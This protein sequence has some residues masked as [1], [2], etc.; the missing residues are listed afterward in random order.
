MHKFFCLLYFI[1]LTKLSFGQ[2]FSPK[3]YYFVSPDSSFVGVKDEF[4]KVIIE[5]IFSSFFIDNEDL[6]QPITTELIEFYAL[7]QGQQFDRNKPAMPTGTVY[8]RKGEFLYHAQLYDNGPDYWGEGV[9]R[10]VENGKIGF[11]TKSG[12]KITPAAWDFALPFNYGYAEVME[13]KLMKVYDSSGEHWSIGSDGPVESYLINKKGE[14]AYGYPQAKHP[15]D[16]LYEGKYYPY[17]FEYD[18]KEKQIIEKLQA[19]SIGISFFFCSNTY[20]YEYAPVQLEITAGPS[21]YRK[22]YVV[23]VYEGQK[24]IGFGSEIFVDA[25]TLVPFVDKYD[26]DR[27]PLQQAI[28]ENLTSFIADARNENSIKAKQIA[29]AELKRLKSHP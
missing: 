13:G 6:S 2:E 1:V 3:L 10:Y 17:A 7:P 20:G 12:I 8:N 14:R 21:D 15:K 28:V 5:P 23:N 27:T 16:Y 29:V 9:R 22:Y 4:G 24:G 26:A 11:V 18:Q 25:V 19:D